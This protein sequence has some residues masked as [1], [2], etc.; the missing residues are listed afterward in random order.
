MPILNSVR[1][2]Y[3]A[4]S[5]ATGGVTLGNSGASVPF[6]TDQTQYF[7]AGFLGAETA[8][9]YNLR[10]GSTI[11]TV[12][13][14]R[15][16]TGS[17]SWWFC[18]LSRPS[19]S[20][21]TPIYG[22]VITTP[23][24]G[25]VGETLTFDLNQATI[26]FGSRIIPQTGTYHIGWHSG[27]GGRAGL[28]QA[29]G[30][31]YAT[32]GDDD[33]VNSY[34][35]YPGSGTIFYL[36]A[37]TT[38]PQ[39][40][41]PWTASTSFVRNHIAISVGYSLP[42]SSATV[43]NGSSPENAAVSALAI[44]NLTGTTTN[45]WYWIKPIGISVPH[46][47]YCDMNTNGGGWMLMSWISPNVA[48]NYHVMDAES[49]SLNNGGCTTILT[50]PTVSSSGANHGVQFINSIIENN[51]GACVAAY[52]VSGGTLNNFY[53]NTTATASYLRYFSRGATSST[54]RS[55]TGNQ[56]YKT[57]NTGYSTSGGGGAGQA[58]G[59]T[60]IT[61]TEDGWGVFPYNLVTG[62][63]GN[64]GTAIDPFY[65]VP[66][67]PAPAYANANNWTSGHNAGWGQSV[68]HW[69]KSV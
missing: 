62:Y 33:D 5:L 15:V 13:Y 8:P 44:K 57:C 49:N 55:A 4:G 2:T 59:G 9:S 54:N 22:A 63:S 26:T 32:C 52:R 64:W 38:E 30:K 37:P 24:G 60:S 68:V 56:W 10:N 3:S 1:G 27:T 50:S 23:A 35:V 43:P 19:T 46:Y 6:R 20:T 45:G 58:T 34:N 14:R 7:T 17:Y 16:N 39:L 11:N 69:L 21:F 47:V 48:N 36:N 31:I 66:S 25:T 28:T 67:S 65:N 61:A 41:V 51:R 12:T 29:T 42:L 40:N 53:F 18:I